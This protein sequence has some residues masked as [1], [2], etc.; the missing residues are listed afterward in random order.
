MICTAAQNKEESGEAVDSIGELVAMCERDGFIPRYYVDKPKDK[1]DRVLQDMQKYTHDLVTEEL[2]LENLI[3]NSLKAI[4]LER[5]QIQAASESAED[6]KEQQEKD[7]FD[8]D[9]NVL[10]DADF[11]AFDED[12][13]FNDEEGE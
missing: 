12:E 9:K 8:Y 13:L 6:F 4:E 7:L 5:A 11:M 10:S 2:G 3:Q 1:I